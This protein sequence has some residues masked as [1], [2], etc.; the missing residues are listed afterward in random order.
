MYTACYATIGNMGGIIGPQIYGA[1]GEGRPER[2]GAPDY[3][4]A[5]VTMSCVAL[6][7]ALL[8]AYSSW[9]HHGNPRTD[10][11]F[12]AA[13]KKPTPNDAEDAPLLAAEQRG[14]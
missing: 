14:T 4:Y 13:R 11:F 5:H 3:R 12:S 9:E 10:V 7:G 8:M 1:I 6:V 2:N